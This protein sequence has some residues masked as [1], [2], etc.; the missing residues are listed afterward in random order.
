MQFYND[1]QDRW[2]S[3]AIIQEQALQRTPLTLWANQNY[4]GKRWPAPGVENALRVWFLLPAVAHVS[5]FYFE[6]LHEF[7][8]P[9]SKHSRAKQTKLV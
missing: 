4:W 7:L 5:A 2:H 6:N 8:D 3:L 1:S 9:I